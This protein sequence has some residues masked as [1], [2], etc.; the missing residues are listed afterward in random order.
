MKKIFVII[1]V[2]LNQLSY[3]QNVGINTSNPAVNFDVNGPTWFR[4][5]NTNLFTTPAL[6]GVE[7]FTGRSL[8]GAL[9]AGQAK[10]DLAFNFGGAGG[11]F[12]H[13]ISTRHQNFVDALGNSI[14]FFVNNSTLAQGSSQPGVGNSL[15]LSVGATGVGIGTN[16]TDSKI[17][18]QVAGKS[19]FQGSIVSTDTL[20][21]PIINQ[22]VP[23]AP[24][25]LNGW[26]NNG[27]VTIANFY[28]ENT[29]RVHLAGVI[30]NGNTAT[31][32]TLLILPPGYRPVAAEF[33]SV[34]NFST[35]AQV[36]VN[37]DGSVRLF[38]PA[39]NN[40]GLSLSG[41]SFRAAN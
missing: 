29:G 36:V 16:L 30:K 31:N 6:A 15:S 7:F 21:V 32:T 26:V 27:D 33:F 22:E 10:A 39:N 20:F 41:I 34:H 11:G 24:A 38:G 8:S 17:K 1:A 12:R 13:F 14:D 4:G 23:F 40:T 18:L 28:K 5:Q 37:A 9:V 3:G 19:F 35:S 25:L 2:F